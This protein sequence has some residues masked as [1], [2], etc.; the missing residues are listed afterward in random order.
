MRSSRV[1]VAAVV[2]ALVAVVACGCSGPEP[3]VVP[4]VTG[5]RLDVAEDMLEDAGFDHVFAH[6]VAGG[7]LVHWSSWA[8]VDQVQ[9]AG[10]R[11]DPDDEIELKVSPLDHAETLELLP[12][13]AAVRPEVEHAVGSRPTAPAPS[14]SPSVD[15]CTAPTFVVTWARVSGWTTDDP[16]VVGAHAV[17]DVTVTNRSSEDVKVADFDVRVD[18]WNFVHTGYYT[19]PDGVQPWTIPGQ[20]G[21]TLYGQVLAA[22]ESA[23][24]RAGQYGDDRPS[25]D[26]QDASFVVTEGVYRF[27]DDDV[28][29]RCLGGPGQ[30][31]GVGQVAP[32]DLPRPTEV[33][34]DDSTR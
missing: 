8:V 16:T 6:R 24:A 28:N 11:P 10:S 31:A 5:Q 22:G 21:P 32:V 12:D 25:R 1:V 14:P 34:I 29:A 7:V 27:V 20:F 9:E 2:A 33:E 30:Y 4:D 23:V 13:D 26:P 3:R 18:G 19:M 17:V 15:P